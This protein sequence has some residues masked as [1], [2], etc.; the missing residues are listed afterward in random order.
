MDEAV[1][2]RLEALSEEKFRDFSS[3]LVP[4]CGDMMGVRVPALRA[5]AREA[6]RSGGWQAMLA[7]DD[8]RWF[9][10]RVLRGMLIGLAPASPEQRLAWVRDF[11]PRIDNWAVCDIFCAGLKFAARN[12]EAVWPL[13]EECLASP[14]TYALRFA[15]VMLLDHYLCDEYIG[16]VLERLAA[17][18]SE[19]Y[20]VR[21]AVAW[22]VSVCY[23]RYPE[24]TRPLLEAGR[25][26]RFTHNKSI[27]KICESLRVAPEAKDALR[28]LKS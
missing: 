19:A 26:D 16:A 5:I 11:V 20:Y 17:V 21:M 25:L 18:R 13:L 14:Q 12:R 9:E 23:V 28:R 7:S 1:R 15:V 4:G 2:I 8:D 3:S 27:Q 10:E 22:A 6:V 24:L